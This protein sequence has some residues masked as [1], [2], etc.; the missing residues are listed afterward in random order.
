MRSVN[1]SEPE[2]ASLTLD[3]LPI[4]APHCRCI[5]TAPETIHVI[6]DD[7]ELTLTGVL[8]HDLAEHLNGRLTLSEITELMVAA[9]TATRDEVPA[10]VEILRDHGFVVDARAHA[11]DA[12]LYAL[13]W[14]EGSVNASLA[15]VGI[16]GL[17]H[18]PIDAVRDG[19]R[20][21]GHVVTD[22]SPDVVVMLVDDHLHPEVGL[23]A[24]GASVPVLMAR[25][26]GP[27]PVVGPWL[28]APGPCHAC[29][30]SRLRFNRQVEAR[31]LGDNDRMGPTAL[32]WTGST[33]A[34]AAAEIALEIARFRSGR[35]MSP[36]G[37]DSSAMLVIDHLTGE[38]RLHA[39]VRRPQCPECGTAADATPRP[40]LLTDVG[41]DAPDDGSYR[42]HSPAQTLER[43][44]HHVSKVTGVV[45]YLTAT[46]PEDHVVQVVA[47]GVNLAQVRKGGSASGFRQGAGGKGT[48]A[49][50][51]RAGAL[52]EAIERYSG[53]F[54]GEEARRKALMSELDPDA[55]APNSVQLFSEAQF[56]DRESWNETHKAM[57]RVPK[58]FDSGQE[59]EWSP[60][61][62]LR[63]DQPRWLPT[64]LSYYGY[65]GGAINGSMADSNGNA[66]GTC[67]EDAIL[68]GFFEL[69]ERDA[70]AVWWYNRIARPGVDLSAYR[71]DFDEPYFDRIRG[72]YSRELDRDL[73]ALDLT[74]DFGIPAFVAVSHARS[75][76]PRVL[77]GFG[78]H[79][80]A[81]GALLRALTEMNQM[82]QMAD[83]LDQRLAQGAEPPGPNEPEAVWWAMESMDGQS[84]LLPTGPDTTPDT[85]AHDW[86]R[87]GKANVDRAVALAAERGMDFIVLD[88]TRPD[89]GLSVVKVLVP[90]MRHFWPRFA[91]G[92]LYDVPVELGWLDHPLTETE[93]NSTPIFW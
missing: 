79:R 38:R 71:R 25:I 72:H 52:A 81:R 69:I 91:P 90:G 60:A 20:A 24:A 80:D 58:P 77:T 65:F 68:Q 22:D 13:W 74:S 15:S 92:R 62:S 29:L 45:E 44:G 40:V 66:A 63:D 19:L 39:V 1:S 21:H 10:A 48:T 78:A 56:A 54:T 27:R 88:Q 73:W 47:S 75:G 16:V 28:G 7:D 4:L 61:W 26:A 84:H 50:Q 41:L 76:R 49:L 93:L 37:P 70:V 11:D 46:Q 85:H 86:D 51:A 53:T 6:S 55:I 64:P 42:M 12:S 23:V 89:I 30:A 57:H 43:Y 59:I 3:S 36:A 14:R 34:H 5:R 83:A 67:L 33:A 31:L 35:R 32:G 2:S 8:F 87:S 82:L 17:G 18:V 9:G